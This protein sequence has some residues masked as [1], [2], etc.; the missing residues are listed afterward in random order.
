MRDVER[1]FGRALMSAWVRTAWMVVVVLALV[2]M[3]GVGVSHSAPTVGAAAPTVVAA[4]ITSDSGTAGH[5]ESTGSAAGQGGHH[6]PEPGDSAAL[7]QA[8]LAVLTALVLV[9]T[10]FLLTTRGWTRYVRCLRALRT[11]QFWDP[12]MWWVHPRAHVLC[13]MRT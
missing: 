5:V 9:S 11:P 7:A 12:A 3:H 4:S 1:S 13:V 8:C 2:M 10:I 6:E